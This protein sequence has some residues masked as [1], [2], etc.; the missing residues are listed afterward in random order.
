MHTHVVLLTGAAGAIGQPLLSELTR[1]GDIGRVYGLQHQSRLTARPDVRVVDGDV[2]RGEDL[3]LSAPDIDELISE[4]TA[5]VHA[6]A[7]TRFAVSSDVAGQTNV[8][9][10]ANLLAF[11]ARCRRL[12]RVLAL[13]TTHV[14][15]R[16]TG[17]IRESELQ[18]DEGFVNGYEASKYAAEL[19][20]RGRMRDLPVAVCRISTAIGD[21]VDGTIARQG[22]IHHAVRLMYAGLAPMIPGSEESPVDFVAVDHAARGVALLATDAFAAGHTWHLSA[23]SDT[24]RAGELLD[25]TMECF[26]TYR[27]AWRK[28]TIER[29]AVVDLETFELFCRSAD[30]AGT[31]TLRAAAAVMGA[32]APQLAFPK[33]FDDSACRHTLA[34]HGIVAPPARE[35]WTRAVRHLITAQ[36]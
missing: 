5:I 19:E 14:A 36:A 9:G 3:G 2:T 23:G 16:R 18:H 8:V 26:L 12:D 32:F 15:G 11:A 6:A 10:T 27:P 1:R 13:S 35:T 22:A 33:R 25:L 28:R 24:I 34:S 21:S 31:P 30:Q 7:D 29:P 17:L 20:L 4:V